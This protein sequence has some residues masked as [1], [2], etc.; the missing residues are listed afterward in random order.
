[1]YNGY[2]INHFLRCS[3]DESPGLQRTKNWV[4]GKM[5]GTAF[6]CAFLLLPLASLIPLE[7]LLRRRG[8]CS[9]RSKL[10]TRERIVWA[11]FALLLALSV[12]LGRHISIDGSTYAGTVVENKISPYG[13]MDVLLLLALAAYGTVVFCLLHR[14]L[15]RIRTT[16]RKAAREWQP[17]RARRVA[18]IA[19]LMFLCHLPYF[20]VYF[21]GF[22]FGDSLWSIYQI[23][24]QTFDNHHPFAYTAFIWACIGIADAFGFGITAG[25]ALYSLLQMIAATATF[26]Y[27]VVWVCTR[28]KLSTPWLIALT[29][30]YAASPYIATYS[31]AMW[32]DPIFSYALVIVSLM[33]ADYALT[34][35]KVAS[36]RSWCTVFALLLVVVGLFRSNGLA[37]LVCACIGAIALLATTQK[38]PKTVPY[39]NTRTLLALLGGSIAVCFVMLGPVYEA[40]GVRQAPHAEGVGVPLAQMARVVACDGTISDAEESYLATLLPIEEYRTAYTP[41]CIDGI[42]WHAG[43]DDQALDDPRFWNCW[44]SMGLRNPRMYFEAWELQTFGFWTVNTLACEYTSNIRGGVPRNTNESYAHD[45]DD[46]GIWCANLLGNDMLRNMFPQDWWSIPVG[47]INW[48]LAWLI[49]TLAMLGRKDLVFPLAPSLGV[50]ASLIVASPLWYWPR[51]G[52]CEQFL[53]PFY[54]SLLLFALTRQ[55]KPKA[56]HPQHSRQKERF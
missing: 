3:L 51:Y 43:F 6:A 15:K 38:R 31:V 29:A 56:I 1:M 8:E 7:V 17:I 18:L 25:C 50:A 12:I 28:A 55:G 19:C 49:V 4:E 10:K 52:A 5:T 20:L 53:L 44:M 22:L 46:Y 24:T 48:W 32:K 26:A 34:K 37:A 14:N 2:V 9:G 47:A 40:L 35:G 45:L 36:S 33:L 21:P 27:M 11:I 42:K 23:T 41:T 30:L 13:Y 39:R 54:A 16:K